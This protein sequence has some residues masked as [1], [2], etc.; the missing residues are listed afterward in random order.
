MYLFGVIDLMVGKLVYVM[1]PNVTID[2][3]DEL[4]TFVMAQDSLSLY[5][6]INMYEANEILL[7]TPFGAYVKSEPASNI[8]REFYRSSNFIIV[9]PDE[10]VSMSNLH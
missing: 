1:P 4:P 9:E 8:I 2:L 3:K 10:V 6:I 5:E 7:S